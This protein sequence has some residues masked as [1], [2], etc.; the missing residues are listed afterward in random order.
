MKVV[1]FHMKIYV[2]LMFMSSESIQKILPRDVG[3]SLPL[4][5]SIVAR[6]LAYARGARRSA[7]YTGRCSSLENGLLSAPATSG[8]SA[9]RR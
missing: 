8:S 3:R 1:H 7:P 2:M 9:K 5:M 6:F 4:Q